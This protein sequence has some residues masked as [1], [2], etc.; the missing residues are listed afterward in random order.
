MTEETTNTTRQDPNDQ[1]VVLVSKKESFWAE[2]A[3]WSVII[4]AVIAGVSALGWVYFSGSDSSGSPSWLHL[5]RRGRAPVTDQA[6]PAAPPVKYRRAID[7]QPLADESEDNGYYA[8]E[9]ENMID[10][11]P[12]SGLARASLVI[13]APVEGGITRFLAVYA[14]ADKVERVGPVRSARPYFLDWA[15]EF[16]ALYAHCGGSPEALSDIKDT[17]IR[18]LNEFYAGKYFWRDTGRSAP[19]N[20]YTSTDLLADAA[21]DKFSDYT[22]RHAPGRLFKEEAAAEDR[23]ETSTE[24]V[25]DYSTEAYRASWRYDR[26]R[27]DYRRRQGDDWQDDE[28]GLPVRAKNVVVQFHK[29][30]VLDA[31][32]RRSIETIGEGK[33]LVARDGKT[34]VAIWRKQTVTDRTGYYDD[35][36]TELPLNAGTTWMEIVP[37]DAD[38][39]Y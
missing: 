34:V 9:V 2:T 5:F 17:R 21:I 26:E 22:V 39:T 24:I 14:A 23:P 29:I 15:Q 13:E 38:V 25:I 18:D 12:L 1:R 16:D 32:G 10:G 30:R 36:E 3:A 4:F 33:A 6:K 37:L 11:R 31:I 20:V 19:H 7:G 35:Q 28:G 27:N 8:V